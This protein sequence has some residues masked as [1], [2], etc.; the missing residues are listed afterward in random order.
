M[1]S[2]A[3]FMLA[4][5]LRVL[6]VLFKELLLAMWEKI[7][8]FFAFF[9]D[10]FP[11]RVLGLVHRLPQ[12][13]ICVYLQ[14]YIHFFPL[15]VPNLHESIKSSYWLFFL[16]VKFVELIIG[17]VFEDVVVVQFLLYLCW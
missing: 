13:R 8:T 10:G 16:V 7:S 6:I 9:F 12:I 5:C 2:L 11:L 15:V 4:R 17:K 1:R 3:R 14:L